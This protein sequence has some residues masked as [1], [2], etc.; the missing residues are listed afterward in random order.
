[1]FGLMHQRFELFMRGSL[2][3]QDSAGG[4]KRTGIDPFVYEMHGYAG[5][6]DSGIESLTDRVHS[7]KPGQKR[8]VDVD[9]P[10]PESLYEPW[11]EQLHV[12]GADDQLSLLALQPVG[13]CQI[14]RCAV[15]VLIGRKGSGRDPGLLRSYQRGSIGLVGSNTD[16]PD[17]PLRGRPVDQCLEVRSLTGGENRDL[18]DA[19]C[20]GQAELLSVR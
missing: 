20:F 8:G 15:R 14:S 13:E 4:D 3:H 2:G 17:Q 5:L 12:A 11:I 10:V 16:Y 6:G 9:Y 1:M 18:E 19:H 7:R